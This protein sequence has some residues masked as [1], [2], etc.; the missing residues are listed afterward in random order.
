MNK[1][2]LFLNGSKLLNKKLFFFV[3]MFLF[4]YFL[5]NV[6]NLQIEIKKLIFRVFSLFFFE[7]SERQFN[8]LK[9]LLVA[10]AC[11]KTFNITLLSKPK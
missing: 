11:E 1:I 9:N 2:K 8:F 5:K 6:L 7:T 4:I 3:K 10:K